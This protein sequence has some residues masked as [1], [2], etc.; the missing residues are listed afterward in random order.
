[1]GSPGFANCKFRTL[2]T[3]VPQKPSTRSDIPVQ[4]VDSELGLFTSNAPQTLTSRH[5]GR[6]SLAATAWLGAP[7]RIRTRPQRLQTYAWRTQ[8]FHHLAQP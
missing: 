7:E 3:R 8:R 6:A 5:L 4:P 2:L 1:M